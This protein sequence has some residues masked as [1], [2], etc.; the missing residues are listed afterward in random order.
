MQRRAQ[1]KP[2]NPA[3]HH[4][5]SE[6]NAKSKFNLKHVTEENEINPNKASDIYKIKPAIA[7]GLADYL[8]LILTPLFNE[9]IDK[10]E[11]TD[12]LKYTKLIEL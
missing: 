11:Y 10:N 1:T 5:Q 12:S 4:R 8:P 3:V 6:Q 2:S 7:K 9:S